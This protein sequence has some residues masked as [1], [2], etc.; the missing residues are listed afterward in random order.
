MGSISEDFGGLKSISVHPASPNLL[1]KHGPLTSLPF[2]TNES[3]K[4][5]WFLTDL[6]FKSKT[7]ALRHQSF[8]LLSLPD[9][10]VH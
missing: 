1:T 2:N 4:H 6:K 7:T 9:Q 3:I 10:I 8:Q 5:S